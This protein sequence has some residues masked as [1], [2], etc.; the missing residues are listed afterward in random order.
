MNIVFTYLI[1][2][3]IYTIIMWI[4]HKDEL[5]NYIDN[6]KFNNIESIKPFLLGVSAIIIV[7]IWPFALASYII[8]FLSY[9]KDKLR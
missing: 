6:P 5:V 4:V 2:G 8:K 7:C 9:L 1:L 3:L